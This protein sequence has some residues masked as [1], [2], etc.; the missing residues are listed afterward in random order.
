[1]KYVTASDKARHIAQIAYDK[2]GEDITLM[3]MRGISSVCDWY[4]LVSGGSS[5]QI[6][7]ISKEVQKSL[8]KDR[9]APLHIEGKKGTYWTLLDCE[10]VIVHVF[11]QGARDFYGLERLWSDAPSEHFVGKCLAQTLQKT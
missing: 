2:K 4:V 3:D 5:R 10:D 6:N 11:S 1:V 7:A 8:A 9:I